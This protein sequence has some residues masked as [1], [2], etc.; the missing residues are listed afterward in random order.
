M[1]N[2]IDASDAGSVSCSTPVCTKEYDE[3][4]PPVLLPDGSAPL[5]SRNQEESSPAS[6]DCHPFTMLSKSPW[7]QP[8]R[9]IARGATVPPTHQSTES[10]AKTGLGRHPPLPWTDYLP[11]VDE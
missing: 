6:P 8:E 5:P 7:W 1:L 4:F 3:V 2:P 10:G 11:T 9:A